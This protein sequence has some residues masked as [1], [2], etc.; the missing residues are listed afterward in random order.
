MYLCFC[1]V[2]LV[3]FY[4]TRSDNILFWNMLFFPHN[5]VPVTIF[6]VIKVF[7]FDLCIWIKVI[8]PG[9]RALLTK[10]DLSVRVLQICQTKQEKRECRQ[11]LSLAVLAPARQATLPS[12][13][14]HSRGT[15]VHCPHPQASVDW[16]KT[17]NMRVA[18]SVR[19]G[20]KWGLQTG[21]RASGS[22]RRQLQRGRGERLGY[23]CDFGEGEYT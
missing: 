8:S 20:A 15:C 18:S 12:W 17:H 10:T 11:D 1:G 14:E 21:V 13:R 16:K 6:R 2:C 7:P 9:R 22:S 19:I 5:T 3:L 23:I 4:K